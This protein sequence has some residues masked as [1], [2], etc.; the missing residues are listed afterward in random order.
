[1]TAHKQSAL[2]ATLQHACGP[3][4]G[5]QVIPVRGPRRHD[6]YA[7]QKRPYIGRS[8]GKRSVQGGK[9]KRRKNGQPQPNK[10]AQAGDDHAQRRHLVVVK[11]DHTVV[12]CQNR[13]KRAKAGRQHEKKTDVEARLRAGEE[14]ERKRHECQET[15]GQLTRPKPARI[16]ADA[17]PS[18]GEIGSAHRVGKEFTDRFSSNPAGHEGEHG[19][20]G[21]GQSCRHNRHVGE[22]SSPRATKGSPEKYDSGQNSKG[23]MVGA[24]QTGQHA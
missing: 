15:K 13:K 7:D 14:K 18:G 22:G 6:E 11:G 2:G 17:G 3:L 10:H 24:G 5:Q 12:I 19:S 9:E 1:M 4:P 8:A 20:R 21:D 23:R 16:E